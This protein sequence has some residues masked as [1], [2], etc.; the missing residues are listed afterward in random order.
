MWEAIVDTCCI[1]NL[2]ATGE[3]AAFLQD[4]PMR[5]YIARA[6]WAESLF[7]R[8]PDVDGDPARERID[9]GRLA[10]QGLITVTEPGESKEI[11]LYVQLA[12][13]LDDGEAMGLAIAKVR[14]WV[15]AT[16]DRKARRLAATLGV[17][18]VTTPELMQRWANDA[19][20]PRAKLTSLLKR[21]EHAARFVPAE[22]APG[23]EWWV[24]L[25]GDD[26]G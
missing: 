25:A 1:I 23:Y 6:A 18:V 17:R 4:S 2:Y 8:F 11:E 3:L 12:A 15:L 7:I 14:N 22:D 9:L 24:E 20:M 16:D 10:S 21:I 13:Q 19:G 26:A 5:F